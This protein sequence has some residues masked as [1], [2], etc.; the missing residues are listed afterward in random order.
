[1]NYMTLSLISGVAAVTY[2]LFLAVKIVKLPQGT[3][4]M[5]AIA[6]AIAEGAQAFL[7]RQY[8][9][10]G[11]LAI[12]IVILLAFTLGTFSAAAFAIGAFCSAV[13]GFIGMNIA[14]RANIRT[15]QAAKEGLGAALSVAF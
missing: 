8:Q 15:S 14:V 9:T 2:G 12:A 4:D 13:A 7:K 11:V 10:V 6:Q 1:M 3:P 5:N